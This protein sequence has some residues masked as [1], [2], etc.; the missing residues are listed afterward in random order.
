M[1][2][3]GKYL[4]DIAFDIPET[5][6]DK[7]DMLLAFYK[8]LFTDMP[9]LQEN[10]RVEYEGEIL[11]SRGPNRLKKIEKE[12]LLQVDPVE[13]LLGLTKYEMKH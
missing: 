5:Q 6:L 3:N 4:R 7:Y 12:A 1:L 10:L 8:Q 9:E 13:I 11:E 2:Q